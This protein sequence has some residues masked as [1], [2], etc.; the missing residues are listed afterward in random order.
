MIKQELL[1]KI[2]KI[3]LKIKKEN[4]SRNVPSRFNILN[5]L[6]RKNEIFYFLSTKEMSVDIIHY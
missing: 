5:T 6:K 2:K 1:S 3:D 4:I